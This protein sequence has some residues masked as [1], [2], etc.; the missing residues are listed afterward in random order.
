MVDRHR[1]TGQEAVQ[2]DPE[3]AKWPLALEIARGTQSAE[4]APT[5]VAGVDDK[6]ALTGR[7][8]PKTGLPQI[9]LAHYRTMPGTRS[10]ACASVPE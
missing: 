2:I 5:H 6:P 8:K 3:L 10:V 4:I 9:R 7:S 1:L